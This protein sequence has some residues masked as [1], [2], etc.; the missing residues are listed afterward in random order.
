MGTH[1]AC[2]EIIPSPLDDHTYAIES[3][4]EPAHVDP[5]IPML[6]KPKQRQVY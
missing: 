6:M 5:H 4:R 2:I 3:N 1:K